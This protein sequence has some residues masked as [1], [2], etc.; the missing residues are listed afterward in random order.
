M[1]KLGRLWDWLVPG[2]RYLDPMGAM[3]FY[4]AIDETPHPHPPVEMHIADAL[5][6]FE[7]IEA[8][9]PVRVGQ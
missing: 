8:P 6:V 2:L 3:A 5:R 4:Q 9:K 1:S 7:L